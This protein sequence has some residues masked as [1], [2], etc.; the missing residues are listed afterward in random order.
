MT[1][2]IRITTFWAL[3]IAAALTSAYV[4]VAANPP[5]AIP[6]GQVPAGVFH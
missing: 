3:L 6:G 1:R 5:A 2:R 4:I